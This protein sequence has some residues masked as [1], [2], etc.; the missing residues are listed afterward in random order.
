GRAG[1]AA[2]AGDR[3]MGELVEPGALRQADRPAVGA[4]DRPRAPHSGLRGPRDLPPD[5]PL[6][7]RLRPDRRRPVAR[8]R[9]A[10]PLQAARALCA[11][12]LVLPHRALLRGTTTDRPGARV[13]RAAAERVGV[14][15]R[16]H[17]L[18]GVLRL[19]AVPAR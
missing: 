11:L 12:R 4:E 1:A 15:R 7:V 18:D 5:L 10:L 3:P 14:A 6:R 17:L 16:L 2:R 13:R 8:A 9:P 19:V